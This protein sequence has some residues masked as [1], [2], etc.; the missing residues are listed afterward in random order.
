MRKSPH[1]AGLSVLHGGLVVAAVVW[2]EHD[3]PKVIRI[4]DQGRERIEMHVD[5]MMIPVSHDISDDKACFILL[6]ASKHQNLPLD[7]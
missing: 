4:C 2:L 1:T 3:P 7:W 5:L 6:V